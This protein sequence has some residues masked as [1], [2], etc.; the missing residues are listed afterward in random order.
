MV[1][2]DAIMNAYGALG[3]RRAPMIDGG[4]GRAGHLLNVDYHHSSSILLIPPLPTLLSR[5][6]NATLY[7][8]RNLHFF[9]AW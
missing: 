1:N 5:E 9:A 2:N 6:N 7:S 4:R 3:G 8:G